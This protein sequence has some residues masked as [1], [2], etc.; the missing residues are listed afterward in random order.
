ME[1][2]TREEARSLTRD[3]TRNFT[4]DDES[5]TSFS[6]YCD[7]SVNAPVANSHD[8]PEDVI[9]SLLGKSEFHS[10]F[11]LLLRFCNPSG[12]RTYFSSL[13]NVTASSGSGVYSVYTPSHV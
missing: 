3:E 12:S 7:A 1:P 11:L 6:D 5:V 4:R 8:I 10:Y 13:L 2:F 9:G